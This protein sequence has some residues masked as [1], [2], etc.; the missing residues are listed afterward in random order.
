MTDGDRQPIPVTELLLKSILPK[1]R[2]TGVAATGIRLNQKFP[3]TGIAMTP[4]IAIPEAQAVYGE[5]RRVARGAD[6]HASSICQTVVDAIG[7]RHSAGQTAEVV[8]IHFL[9]LLA[10]APRLARIANALERKRAEA[11][12]AELETQLRQAQKLAA[13]RADPQRFD[14]VLTD[15]VMPELTGTQLAVQLHAIRSA[16][17]IIL[18]TGYGGP[19][20]P[21]QVRATGTREILQ[22]PL[23]SRDLAESIA[24]HLPANA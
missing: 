18:M 21:H 13:F 20:L 9:R 23:Q 14:L 1:P 6:K 10:L 16:L 8:V 7:N 3:A 24:R 11:E 12:K 17:P 22:K 19:I 2:C 4:D 5:L 15:E